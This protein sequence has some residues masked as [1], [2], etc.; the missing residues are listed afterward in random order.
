MLSERAMESNTMALEI[1]K[2]AEV[3]KNHCETVTEN[4]KETHKKNVTLILDAIEE[5]KVVDEIKDIAEEIG[6]ISKK[7]N[8]LALNAAIEAARAGEAGKGFAIVASEVRGLS[9]Q[10]AESVNKVKN[11][12][13]RVKDAFDNLTN[14]SRTVLDY[15]EESVVP[16]FEQLKSTGTEYE[17]DAQKLSDISEELAV[18]SEQIHRAI[19]QLTGITDSM[20]NNS[21]NM[22]HSNEDTL[23]RVNGFIS[24]MSTLI[25]MSESQKKLAN[26]LEEM[27]KSFKVKM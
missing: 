9:E 16:S 17:A 19:A 24:Q 2:R 14:N 23:N 26:E 6:N 5:G 20:T 8:L 7:T 15:I 22:L 21:T 4:S 18:M 11:I 1:R 3:T 27:S 25:E 12:V 10:S 13:N